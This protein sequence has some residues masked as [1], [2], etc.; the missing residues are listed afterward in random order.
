MIEPDIT[1][2][3]GYLS[4]DVATTLYDQLCQQVDWD[5]RM[6]ARK[7]ACFGFSY[8]YSGV[9]YADK[10]MHPLLVPLCDRL[11]QKLGFRPNSCLI[12]YYE[13]GRSRMGFHSDETDNLE[14]GTEIIII[15]LG[16]KR[17]LAFRSRDDYER[18]L[19]YVLSHGS[20]LYMSQLTQKFWSHAIKR[21]SVTEG[22]ISLTF[23][24]IAVKN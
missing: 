7:T 19:S 2:L 10:P 24:R 8:D 18:R 4:P 9:S 11:E 23:R 20:L 22:R 15:S 6:S 16:T 14:E 5:E 1:I 3:P 12:N 21:E 13:T 17:K